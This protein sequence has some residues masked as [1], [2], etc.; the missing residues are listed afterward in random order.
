MKGR[1]SSR[2]A[3]APPSTRSPRPPRRTHEGCRGECLPKLRGQTASNVTTAA[4]T[5]SGLKLSSNRRVRDRPPRRRRRAPRSI[6]SWS[7]LQP[8]RVPV[9]SRVEVSLHPCESGRHAAGVIDVIVLDKDRVVQTHTV[10]DPA[11][12]PHRPLF[13]G[14]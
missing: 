12:E 13:K 11:A 8:R 7:G 5:S 3:S 9:V 4:R 10:V 6:R 1:D 2:Y 14:S